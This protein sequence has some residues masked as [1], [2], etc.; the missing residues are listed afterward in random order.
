M[1]T[2]DTSAGAAPADAKPSALKALGLLMATV[3]LIGG[4]IVLGAFLGNTELYAGFTFLLCWMVIE[5]G[6]LE[7]LP[8]SIVGAAVGLALGYA[9]QMLLAGPLGTTGGYVFG[10]LVL[11]V[12]Y[13]QFMGW[14]RLL[15]NMTTMTFLL[16][17]T[18][19]HVQAH[20]DFRNTAVGLALG[21][22]Y[23]GLILGI[24][25][26]VSAKRSAAAQPA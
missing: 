5:H 6:K 22:V 26:R 10:A 7:R 1:T 23:F 20:A 2:S 4:Y 14:L 8:H 9:M 15:V 25:A 17:V 16:V 24:F 18:I 19:P 21:V 12:L 11:V 3:L 13:C